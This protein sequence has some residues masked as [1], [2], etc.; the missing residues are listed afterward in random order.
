[1]TQQNATFDRTPT[2]TSRQLAEARRGAD[3]LSALT[4]LI[5]LL[6][7]QQSQTAKNAAEA[8]DEVYIGL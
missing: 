5:A 2:T 8:R 1:M 6:N 4:R 3:H 7:G